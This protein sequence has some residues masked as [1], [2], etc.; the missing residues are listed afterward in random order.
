MSNISP[1]FRDQSQSKYGR[2]E[3]SDQKEE[4]KLNVNESS[5]LLQPNTSRYR[6][7]RPSSNTSIPAVQPSKQQVSAPKE[8]KKTFLPLVFQPEP[9]PPPAAPKSNLST[10]PRPS[11]QNIHRKRRASPFRPKVSSH[12]LPH[13]RKS[14]YTFV[15]ATSSRWVWSLLFCPTLL[16]ALIYALHQCTKYERWNHYLDIHDEKVEIVSPRIMGRSAM[17]HSQ[18][19]VLTSCP[20]T[21]LN[22]S[23]INR[24]TNHSHSNRS[25]DINPSVIPPEISLPISLHLVSDHYSRVTSREVLR[26]TPPSRGYLFDY[27]S[28]SLVYVFP[29]PAIN[30]QDHLFHWA[31]HDVITSY[32]VVLTL[33]CSAHPCYDVREYLFEGYSY[34]SRYS[35]I[36]NIESC[37]VTIVT[38]ILM[39][40][41]VVMTWKSGKHQS[42]EFNYQLTS[43]GLTSASSSSTS[44]S[45]SSS[46]SRI[47]F[48]PLDCILPEQFCSL[49]LLFSLFLYNNIFGAVTI[50][51]TSTSTLQSASEQ[52]VFFC[53]F[54]RSVGKYGLWFGLYVMLTGLQYNANSYEERLRLNEMKSSLLLSSSSSSLFYKNSADPLAVSASLLSYDEK[55]VQV[56]SILRVMYEVFLTKAHPKSSQFLDFILT[57]TCFLVITYIFVAIYWLFELKVNDF[58][59]SQRVSDWMTVVLVVVF[60]FWVICVLKVSNLYFL[61]RHYIDWNDGVFDRLYIRQGRNY[62]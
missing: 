26:A 17:I 40:K 49:F 27:D 54:I 35:L 24:Q 14:A 44:S 53:C 4:H 22:N 43:L 38:L 1:F 57:K 20:L 52:W 9:P 7:K 19:F 25:I 11:Q 55:V 41:L 28:D 10:P 32:E 33:D 61:H 56:E 45:P 2:T 29:L 21:L 37:V 51:L 46:S 5:P 8:A 39:V 42:D 23:L 31:Q 36:T 13:T 62:I 47:F 48:K 18:L 60:S 58:F 3:K 50:L 15:E 30:M 6:D 12:N 59:T 34:T 16:I